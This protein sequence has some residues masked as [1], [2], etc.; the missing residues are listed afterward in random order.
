MARQTERIVPFA[1]RSFR[2]RQGIAKPMKLTHTHSACQLAERTHHYSSSS[3]TRWIEQ[4]KRDCKVSVLQ[5][6]DYNYTAQNYKSGRGQ[7][8]NLLS[9]EIM[10]SN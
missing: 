10:A 6:L 5:L 9:R 7:L 2:Q 1:V 8:P 3:G 4:C